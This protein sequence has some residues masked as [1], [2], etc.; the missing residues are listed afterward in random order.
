MLNLTHDFY[1]PWFLNC[2]MKPQSII[3]S[4]YKTPVSII[5]LLFIYYFIYKII[6]SRVSK[7]WENRYP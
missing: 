1:H 4:T 3:F 5:F 2:Q 7:E 6:L